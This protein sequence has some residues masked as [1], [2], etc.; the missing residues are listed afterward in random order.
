[1]KATS[2]NQSKEPAKD[3]AMGQVVSE[4][5]RD[6]FFLKNPNLAQMRC[7]HPKKISRKRAQEHPP[8]MQARDSDQKSGQ[9]VNKDFAS[10]KTVDVYI[11]NVSA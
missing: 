9:D 11:V 7:Y 8:K 2:R 3:S 10:G 6:Y 4:M 1:M 5:L